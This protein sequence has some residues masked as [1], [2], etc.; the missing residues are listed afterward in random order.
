MNIQAIIFD[1]AGT[2]VD[3]G[4]FA[5]L[6]VFL[7]IFGDRGIFLTDAEA[8]EPMGKLKWDHIRA[9][10]DMPRI[11]Q[12]WKSA[13]GAE[14]TNADVD[15]LY[16]AF[17]P[18]LF[19]T[20]KNYTTPIPD[21]VET[22]A[23]LRELGLKIGSS[24]GYTKA[25]MDVVLP[26]AAKKGYAPDF[27]IAS[28]EVPAGRPYPWMIF[29][30]CEKLNVYPLMSVVKI[31]DTVADIQ[32]GVNAACWSVGIIEGSSELGLTKVAFDALYPIDQGERM[33]IVRERFYEAGADFVINRFRDIPD[34]IER[35]NTEYL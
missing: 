16:A 20:L 13:F 11:A 3:Y 14:P 31:G 9:I 6:E 30:N 19:A 4:C 32:E 2:T 5:P 10:C 25:M 27:C 1:W 17:E 8:R 15:S 35:I 21:V 23:Q 7:K 22:V 18:A 34:L 24:T 12:T 28:D 26:E 29:R 33:A